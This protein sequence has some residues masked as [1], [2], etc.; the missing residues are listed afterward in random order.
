M[1]RYVDVPHET[2]AK[3]ADDDDDEEGEDQGEEDRTETE[4]GERQGALPAEPEKP[5]KTAL[6][7]HEMR[8]IKDMTVLQR[9]NQEEFHMVNI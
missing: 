7:E 5:I 6:T 4:D 2:P 8:M 1:Y 9:T 3:G